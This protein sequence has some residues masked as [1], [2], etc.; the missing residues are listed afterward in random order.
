MDLILQHTDVKSGFVGIAASGDDLQ[1]AG[2]LMQGD[3]AGGRVND[4]DA[5]TG[6]LKD[7]MVL[8]IAGGDDV[9]AMFCGGPAEDTKL[10]LFGEDDEMMLGVIR[11]THELHDGDGSVDGKLYLADEA[12]GGDVVDL[13]V[14][15]LCDEEV[16]LVGRCE[17]AD[18]GVRDAGGLVSGDDI[19]VHCSATH[20]EGDLERPREGGMWFDVRF[21]L[22][23]GTGMGDAVVEVGLQAVKRVNVIGQN[24]REVGMGK[25][26]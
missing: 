8:G 9:A 7:E 1:K 19:V 24:W 12:F 22:L 14:V 11:H 25:R 16:G 5:L 13:D 21:G 4:A 23:E 17:I 3:A 2:V 6:H 20:S 26:S 10:V 18:G 15:Y